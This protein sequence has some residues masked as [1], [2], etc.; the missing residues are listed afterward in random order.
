[1]KKRIALFL[2]LMLIAVSA[3]CGGKNGT[4]VRQGNQPPGVE[5]VLKAGMEEEDRKNEEKAQPK[6]SAPVAE[7]ASENTD[8][9]R[10][11]GINE[12]APKP[13]ELSETE[14]ELS[15]TEG[16]DIDLTT[17]SG[18]MVYSEVYN[19]LALPED[20]IGKTV[21]MEGI[22]AL[23]YDEVTGKYYYACIIADATACCSQGIEFVLT[24]D[25][26]YP[27]DYPEE[28]D[29]ISVTGVF[30]TYTEDGYLYCTLRNA[31]LNK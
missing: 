10:Q 29:I 8:S 12:D 15:G 25:Y 27:D 6:E 17:L 30:D 18:T 9:G 3:G 26:T 24:E 28:G 19:M 4:A 7:A 2:C 13:E 23:Y 22:F 16:I 20:Y 11:S 31:T 1:M 14:E 5:E 21:K